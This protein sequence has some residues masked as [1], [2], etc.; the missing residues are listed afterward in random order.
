M[1][2]AT[3]EIIVQAADVGAPHR[4]ERLFVLAYCDVEHSDLFKWEA[5]SEST[6]GGKDVGDTR[7]AEWGQNALPRGR[8]R[9]GDDSEGQ[10]S[11]GVT[12]SGE[13]VGDTRRGGG[14]RRGERGELA[15]ASGANQG[16]G[17]QRERLRD[18]AHDSEPHVAYAT[19]Q[20]QREQ[21]NEARAVAWQDARQAIGSGGIGIWPPGPDDLDAWT[22]VLAEMPQVEP[23]VC[24]VAPR[25]ADGVDLSR[26]QQL[27]IIGNGVV[28]LQAAV[29]F[30]ILADRASAPRSRT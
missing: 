25:L 22:R 19:Q 18:E 26:T 1:G 13:D 20:P 2:Y 28:P 12:E 27:R 4:R 8:G 15:S 24:N 7:R 11:G 17:H 10:A 23:A 3:S 9:Q 30:R 29:A 5:W 16:A 21:D 14:E 6:R